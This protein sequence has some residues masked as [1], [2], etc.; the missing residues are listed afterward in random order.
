MQLA[1]LL[2]GAAARRP[3]AHGSSGTYA[4]LLAVAGRGGGAHPLS[5]TAPPTGLWPQQQ[6]HHVLLLHVRSVGT[7]G[8]G[9]VPPGGPA[10]DKLLAVPFTATRAQADAAF[11]QFHSRH[12]M[13]NPALPRWARPGRESYVPYWVGDATVA[14]R[15]QSA[16][17]GRDELVRKQDPRTGR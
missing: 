13:Q 1:P 3:P 5:S 17:V 10:R 16:E 14:V 6:H 15:L 7:S 11:K 12:W 8:K 4:A 9:E 2:L